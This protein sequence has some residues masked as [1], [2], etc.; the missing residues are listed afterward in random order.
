MMD[1]PAGSGRPRR[2]PRFEDLNN[3]RLPVSRQTNRDLRETRREHESEGTLGR[4][5]E[6]HEPEERAPDGDEEHKGEVGYME[7]EDKQSPRSQMQPDTAPVSS[8]NHYLDDRQSS[9]RKVRQYRTTVGLVTGLVSNISSLKDDAT[10]ASKKQFVEDF[11]DAAS[12]SALDPGFVRYKVFH[13]LI[14]KAFG[15][16]LARQRYEELLRRP[17]LR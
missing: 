3:Q 11:E 14:K 6:D 10:N 2:S 16:G 7:P 13:T 12:Y 17:H 5:W 4:I 1:S 15:S 9:E 8:D